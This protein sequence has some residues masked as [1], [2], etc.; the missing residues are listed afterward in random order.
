MTASVSLLEDTQ[1]N[2][3][4]LSSVAREE[5]EWLDH[6]RPK[7]STRESSLS[8][9]ASHDSKCHKSTLPY[10]NS[11][12]FLFQD[13]ASSL[14]AMLRHCLVVVQAAIHHVV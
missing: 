6:E 4:L 7:K 5:K 3:M 12:L 1:R 14:I 11:M 2:P 10:I 9:A 13:E 8:W